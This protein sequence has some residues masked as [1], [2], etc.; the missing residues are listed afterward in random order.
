MTKAV[1]DLATINASTLKPAY[2][3]VNERRYYASMII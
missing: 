1:V 3:L 2:I